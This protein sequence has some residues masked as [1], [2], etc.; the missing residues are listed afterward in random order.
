MKEVMYCAKEDKPLDR[1]ELV[2]GFEYEKGQYVVVEPEELKKIAPPT[3]TAMEILQFVRMD[4]VDPIFLETSYY[5]APES[6]VARPYS[7]LFGAMK[8]TGYDALAKLTMHNREHIVILR[9]AAHG[10]V[11]HT[12]YFVDEL[13][14][15]KD[16]PVPKG[17]KFDKKELELAKKLIETLAAPFKPE[18]FHDE[19]KQN[20][21]KL[22]EAKR[23]GRKVTPIT[24]PKKAP[25]IDLMKAL[26]QSLAKNT[27]KSATPT[28]KKT[29]RKRT[30][31]A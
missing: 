2:K 23:K 14:A 5:M 6:S 4:E 18:Q 15:G 29:G 24:Q 8:Q 26:Q 25:V 22:I 21:E 31:A 1:D 11:L 17:K 7:L 13:H 3:A 10:I 19:Y 27:G 20:V 12:M 9:P 30:A 16:I 28:T